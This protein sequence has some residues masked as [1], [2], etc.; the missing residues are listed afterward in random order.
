MTFYLQERSLLIF[1]KQT[2]GECRAAVNSAGGIFDRIPQGLFGGLR[3]Y[4][5]G[6]C[7]KGEKL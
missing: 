3:D 6:K 1:N 4:S 2:T 7:L 5:K